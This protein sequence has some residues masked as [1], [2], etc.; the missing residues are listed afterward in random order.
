MSTLLRRCI[1]R[2]VI[3]V[4]VLVPATAGADPGPGG[5]YIDDNGGVHE[6]A[7]EA[8]T[9]A[10]I[11]RSCNPPQ[12]DRYCPRRPVTRGQMAAFL[13]RALDLERTGAAFAD[14]DGHLFEA[15]IAALA[16]A[17]ITRG[18]DPPADTRFC[19]DAHVTRGQMATF[20]MRALDLETAEST[21]V[22][23]VGSVH[24]DAI[25]ALAAA[26]VTRGCDPPDNTRYC[27]DRAVT[28]A[29]MATFLTRALGLDPVD[30]PPPAHSVAIADRDAWGARAS[31]TS[32]FREHTVDHI[33][34]HHDGG[35]G[36]VF[37][38]ARFRGYQSWHMDHHGWADIA[39]HFIV[40][41]DGAVYEARPTWARGDTATSYDPD[42][43]LLI[44]VEGNFD[45]YRPTDEQLESLVSLMA[46]ASAEWGVDV[47]E[48]EGH[49][50][51]SGDTT[52]PG[53]HLAALLEDGSL[54]EQA[55]H[56][57]DTGGV[58]RIVP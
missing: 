1:S 30:V 21:F 58:T 7:I 46:W 51:H 23:T 20:L 4:V 33:T 38:P 42:G 17:G 27:P 29:E 9:A 26:G 37:G 25:G 14:T 15:E 24:R 11:T 16:A 55:R 10:G 40:G 53:Y 6:G 12:S 3:A 52:C 48:I 39:Y 54:A 57:Q 34:L 44:V 5:T 41:R 31:R 32:Q 2:A 19:P 56:L 45:D 50:H 18:C 13:T 22:D 43:H 36:S 47:S 35:T 8:I 49:R 28:R